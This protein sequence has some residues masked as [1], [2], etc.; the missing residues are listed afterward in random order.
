MVVV[1]I[2]FMLGVCSL[3]FL[4]EMKYWDDRFYWVDYLK[5]VFFVWYLRVD[6]GL[7]KLSE[8][9][10]VVVFVRILL[11]NLVFLNVIFFIICL[12]GFLIRFLGMGSVNFNVIL[13]V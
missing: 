3:V 6:M 13:V 7:F 1:F 10:E 8:G 2:V 9:D 4:E 12:D 5:N 11:I